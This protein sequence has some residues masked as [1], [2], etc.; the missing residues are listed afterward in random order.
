MT[1]SP[2]ETHRL[3]RFTHGGQEYI[4]DLDA[5]EC[6]QV[7]EPVAELLAAR[8][9]VG[10]DVARDEIATRYSEEEA[11]TAADAV[12]AGVARGLFASVTGRVES[13]DRPLIL[14]PQGAQVAQDSQFETGGAFLS[15]RR[16]LGAMAEQATL[17]VPGSRR[18]RIAERVI[19]TPVDPSPDGLRRH[20][21]AHAYDG[22]FVWAFHEDA[23]RYLQAANVPVVSRIFSPRGHNGHLMNEVFRVYAAMGEGDAFVTPSRSV[24]DFYSDYVLDTDCFHVVRN[25]V[26]TELFHP[27]PAREARRQVAA[28]LD[29][30][31]IASGAPI[32]GY[33]SRFQVEKGAE[34][35]ARVASLVPDALFLIVAPHHP[36]YAMDGLPPNVVHAGHQPRES[37]PVYLNSF[38]L[39]CFPSLIGEESFGNALMEAMAC[40]IPPVVPDMDGLPD[41]VGEGGVVVLSER[42]EHDIGSFAAGVSPA[43]YARVVRE[44]LRDGPRLAALRAKALEQ[45]RSWT[46]TAAANS[47]LG[48]FAE[49]RG[50]RSMAPR[51]RY[52][53]RFSAR[54]SHA[55]RQVE[56]CSLLINYNDQGQCPLAMHHYHHT[57]LDGVALR[58]LRGHTPHEVEAVLLDAC[59]SR[60]EAAATLARALGY[61]EATSAWG[62]S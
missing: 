56:P 34:V 24:V 42:Y 19:E 59:G 58:M 30:P 47:I 32:V 40:G 27:M 21:L 33:F 16:L 14:V 51:N 55:T 31:R 5:G 7:S 9:A 52:M 44:L 37:L 12:N 23:R 36:T 6:V 62:V 54:Q 8:E 41:T 25:G 43:A 50:R 3:H 22:V 4:A 49:L 38:D 57:V 29:D 11:E 39:H 1:S 28:A 48:L 15:A 35:F 60:K 46:W 18:A 45:A 26:D 53:V 20:F 13:R 10:F 61:C 17:V 2:D